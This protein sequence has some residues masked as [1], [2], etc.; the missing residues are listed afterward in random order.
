MPLR[1]MVTSGARAA[2]RWRSRTRASSSSKRNGFVIQSS[3]PPSRPATVSRTESRAVSTITGS[4]TRA[5]R[6]SR[7][8]VKPSRP[9]SPMSSTIRSNP[10][11]SAWPSARSPSSATTVVKPL[12][13]RPFWTNE[14]MRSSSSAIRMRFMCRSPA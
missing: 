8:T 12:A 10:P 7:S 4:V 13:R 9:G 5:S 1:N 6:S 3:A 2:V 14:A 11:V